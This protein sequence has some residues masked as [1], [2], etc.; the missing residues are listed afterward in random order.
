M[1]AFEERTK[2]QKIQQKDWIEQQK[3]E[4]EEKKKLVKEEEKQIVLLISR[5]FAKQILELNRTRGMIK[6][7]TDKK[8]REMLKSIQEQNQ[9]LVI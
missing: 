9:L 4:K 7:D 2:A 3:R 5:A 6:D 8:K 1:S